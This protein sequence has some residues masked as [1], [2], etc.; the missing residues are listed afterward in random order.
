MNVFILLIVIGSII[1]ERLEACGNDENFTPYK[2]VWLL[3]IEY[4]YHKFDVIFQTNNT[5]SVYSWKSHRRFQYHSPGRNNGFMYHRDGYRARS[6]RNTSF[7]FPIIS[8]RIPIVAE[9]PIYMIYQVF[10][11][12]ELG[13]IKTVNSV[14]ITNGLYINL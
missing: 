2:F 6:M 13:C 1:F 3:F 5:Y 11:S 7:F 14:R 8:D 10:P 12:T 4:D 9:K